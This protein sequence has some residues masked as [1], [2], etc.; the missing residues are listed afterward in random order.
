MPNNA[1][2]KYG[3]RCQS[4]KQYTGTSRHSDGTRSHD[5]RRAEAALLHDAW[6]RA[7]A[8][9]R[10][11][12]GQRD[13]GLTRDG[14]VTARRERIFSGNGNK[15]SWPSLRQTLFQALFQLIIHYLKRRV[16][17][18]VTFV[19]FSSDLIN[20][21][22]R[23]HETCLGSR[24]AGSR[25]LHGPPK[26]RSWKV[27]E[28]PMIPLRQFRPSRAPSGSKSAKSKLPST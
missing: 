5:A 22:C 13:D 18:S 2:T 14:R 8:A 16:P 23:R 15:N 27:S 20:Q 7:T 9:K 11:P 26:H 24:D 4:E 6:Y 21:L 28:S 10:H 25:T 12:D 19:F 3:S 1:S 17:T